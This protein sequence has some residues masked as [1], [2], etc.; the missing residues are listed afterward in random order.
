[1]N[2]NDYKKSISNLVSAYNKTLERIL[3]SLSST[4]DLNS[5]RTATVIRTANAE[6]DKLRKITKQWGM[7]M[8][9]NYAEA[10]K[11]VRCIR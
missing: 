5:P 1:M 8:G 10:F 2:V 11:L 9:C 3:D 4:I 7:K 6:L